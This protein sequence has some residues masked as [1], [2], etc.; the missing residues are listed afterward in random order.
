MFVCFQERH[1]LH[2]A[3]YVFAVIFMLE[4]VIKVISFTALVRHQCSSIYNQQASPWCESDNRVRG[5]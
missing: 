1:F 5:T 4:M 3:N 2:A